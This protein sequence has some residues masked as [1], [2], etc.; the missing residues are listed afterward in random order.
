MLVVAALTVTVAGAVLETVLVCDVAESQLA[1]QFAATEEDVD[2]AKLIGCPLAVSWTNCAVGGDRLV[3]ALKT[4]RGGPAVKVLVLPIVSVT[5]IGS[6][7]RFASPPVG[8]TVI[9][10]VI[11]PTGSP[12]G[13]TLMLR[14]AGVVTV[15]DDALSHTESDVN[16]KL[17]LPVPNV[18]I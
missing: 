9:V 4:S 1:G 14:V 10:P 6:E 11:A 17:V 18:V 12:A 5:V 7:Y 13:F 8:L 2:S 3:C 16:V 15:A